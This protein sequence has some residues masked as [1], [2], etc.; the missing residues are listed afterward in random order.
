MGSVWRGLRF[1]ILESSGLPGVPLPFTYNEVLTV[2]V[3]CTPANSGPT[4]SI[5]PLLYLARW[6]P[7]NVVNPFYEAPAL[8]CFSCL[9]TLLSPAESVLP[10][11]QDAPNQ[12]RHLLL[13][14]TPWQ[15][16]NRTTV[17]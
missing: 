16:R 4:P 2:P 9:P 17:G 5:T 7:E 14:V 10:T 15:G 1:W 8:P 6:S 11:C 12:L 13:T 3:V